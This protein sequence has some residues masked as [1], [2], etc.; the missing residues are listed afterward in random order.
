LEQQTNTVIKYFILFFILLL[1]Q[2][3]R[4]GLN[5]GWVFGGSQPLAGMRQGVWTLVGHAQTT[6]STR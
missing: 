6:Q 3:T 2:E 4:I 5:L 1:E